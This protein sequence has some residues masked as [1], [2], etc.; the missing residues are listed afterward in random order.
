M[1]TH[2]S[3]FP[4]PTHHENLV[5]VLQCPECGSCKLDISDIRASCF[6]CKREWLVEHAVPLVCRKQHDTYLADELSPDMAAHLVS[7]ARVRGWREAFA[8]TLRLLPGGK[9]RYLE[10][11]VCSSSRALVTDLLDLTESKVV[12]DHGCGWGNLT[13]H[14]AKSYSL[15]K[16]K[17]I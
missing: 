1:T 11:Y 4:K 14:V 16:G 8:Q 3:E 17:I 15:L 9:A 6:I 12:L 2:H 7:Q 13:C 10:R 5:V